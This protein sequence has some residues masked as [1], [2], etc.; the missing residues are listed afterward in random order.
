MEKNNVKILP[1]DRYIFCIH[2]VIEN[3]RQLTKSMP[4]SSRY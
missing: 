3:L 2:I 4:I 1:I